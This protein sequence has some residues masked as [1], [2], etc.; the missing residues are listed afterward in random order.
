MQKTACLT[1]FFF[2][3]YLGP[4]IRQVIILSRFQRFLIV[5]FVDFL[6]QDLENIAESCVFDKKLSYFPWFRTL[7]ET[8]CRAILS[9]TIP[10]KVNIV[11][12]IYPLHSL[13][14]VLIL[15]LTIGKWNKKWGE[16][17][18]TE[19]CRLYKKKYLK[20]FTKR[21][22]PKKVQMILFYSF[23]N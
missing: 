23:L 19:H 18:I 6:V 8:N 20:T 13:R 14:F 21:F 1:S 17:G 12:L 5:N 15:Y 22:L 9:G 2:S 11:S 10:I 4:W 3:P 16:L 7:N